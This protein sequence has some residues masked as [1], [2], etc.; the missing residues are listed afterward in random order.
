GR[1]EHPTQ[2]LLDLLTL[3]Q[4]WGTVAG[5]TVAIVGDI[6]GSRVAR[7]NLHALTTMGANVTLVG[8][9]VMVPGSFASI[10]RGPGAVTI[11]HDFDAVLDVADAVMMLRVQFERG[12]DVTS[13]YRDG[14]GLTESRLQ[15]LRPE[16]VVLHPGPVNRGLEMDDAAVDDRHRSRILRQVTN[17]VAVRMAVLAALVR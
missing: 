17:G 4:A 1:H 5:R 12:S 14:Y 11:T 13:D 7:S 10:T 2:G 6:A 16:V 8:P 3:R 15:R 9:P